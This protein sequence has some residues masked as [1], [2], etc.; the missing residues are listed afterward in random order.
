[1]KNFNL[2]INWTILIILSVFIISADIFIFYNI[3]SFFNKEVERQASE[4]LS[5]QINLVQG[6]IENE[7]RENN[8]EEIQRTI[9]ELGIDKNIKYVFVL[10]EKNV[11][12]FSNNFAAKGKNI[13]KYLTDF[14]REE[15]GKL[16]KTTEI[17][18]RTL[19]GVTTVSNDKAFIT[20]IFPVLY[21]TGGKEIRNLHEYI[22]FIQYDLSHNKNHFDSFL[23]SQFS[24]N[25]FFLVLL[26]VLLWIFFYFALT[27]RTNDLITVTR[28]FGEGNFKIRTGM[29]GKD[30]ISKLGMAFDN[31][32]DKL[33]ESENRYKDIFEN[34]N[35]IIFINEFSEAN[36]FGNFV[37]VNNIAST[38]LGYSKEEFRNFSLREI[39]CVDCLEKIDFEKTG[40]E[41][42]ENSY[43]TFE[44]TLLTKNSVNKIPVE[45]NSHVFS[46]NK[47]QYVISIA[48]DIRE[49]R[50]KEETIKNSLREKEVLIKE[51]HHR[52]KNNLQI[53]S[54]LMKIQARHHED[55]RVLNVLRD[56]QSRVQTMAL[57]HKKIYRSQDL[58]EI[59]FSDYV[60]ELVNTISLSYKLPKDK[61]KI[62][63]NLEKNISLTIEYA[64]PCGMIIN[65]LFSNAVK[66]AFPFGKKGLISIFWGKEGQNYR[67][68][69]SDNGIGLSDELI[70]LEK[71][72]S[73]GLTL[74]NELVN[75]LDGKIQ[76][77]N[78]QGSKFDITFSVS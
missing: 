34:I 14:D 21:S 63:T 49:R 17:V 40:N 60:L 71:T 9:S 38:N 12:H 10:D 27:K 4:V 19:T 41:I 70:I 76:I 1:M 13:E 39:T 67:L 43:A 15:Q 73:M 62:E 72:S 55:P 8:I 59:D 50:E 65:E 22:L 37:D 32:A 74:V 24:Q 28:L 20:A 18:K 30:E 77:D 5:V 54:S 48:R 25:I 36:Q 11:I 42:A 53:I 26:S 58:L 68:C 16:Q 61:I 7:S 6:E 45:I 66:H 47:K 78:S 69:V 23:K 33:V 51:I 44:L 52:V 46:L 35:D 64:I 2:P 31:M 57:I 75:Q 29:S 3:S 56:S